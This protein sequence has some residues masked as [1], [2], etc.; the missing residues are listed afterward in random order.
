MLPDRTLLVGLAL[1]IGGREGRS[2]VAALRAAAERLRPYLVE[3]PVPLGE[4][5]VGADLREWA[6]RHEATLR[7]VIAH[8]LLANA[9]RLWD[10][11]DERARQDGAALAEQAASVLLEVAAGMCGPSGRNDEETTT[12]DPRT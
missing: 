1:D 9:G 6:W 2:G 7:V 12:P 8:R 10:V 4:P 5:P 3:P 11:A